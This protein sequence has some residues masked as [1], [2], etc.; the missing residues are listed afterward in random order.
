MFDTKRTHKFEHAGNIG[1]RTSQKVEDKINAILFSS[2]PCEGNIFILEPLRGGGERYKIYPRPG[3]ILNVKK[4]MY[5]LTSDV[6]LDDS[7]FSSWNN[8]I[9]V[10]TNYDDEAFVPTTMNII[11][12][13]EKRVLR[14]ISITGGAGTSI[15]SIPFMIRNSGY[16]Y[17][18]I[19]IQPAGGPHTVRVSVREYSAGGGTLLNNVVN[20]TVDTAIASF[21]YDVSTIIPVTRG[22]MLQVELTKM[23]IPI[24]VADMQIG[25]IR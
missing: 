4:G 2:W 8:E 14:N 5:M 16:I 10:F 9:E 1:Y 6:S 18:K 20:H 7:L 21:V 12:Q 15:T 22:M 13:Q 17:S 23:T 19:R 11:K 3:D 24:C 25:V